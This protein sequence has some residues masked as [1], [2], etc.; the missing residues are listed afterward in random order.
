MIQGKYEK[1]LVLSLQ[2]YFRKRGYT[3]KPHAKLN[4]AWSN[5]ISDIDVLAFDNKE[6]VAVEVKSKRDV[7][8]RGFAQ[9]EKVAPFVD[10]VFVA[11]DDEVKAN[12]HSK[13]DNGSNG[14]G[15]LYVDL[16]YNN[17]VV[18]KNGKLQLHTPSI[19]QLCYLK[20]CCL[21]EMAREF[22][23]APHQSKQ[24]I[25][26]DLQR[27]VKPTILK[28]KL[29]EIVVYNKVSHQHTQK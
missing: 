25:A 15:I 13:Q 3:A 29:K 23:I 21:Q 20:K 27:K 9:V 16:I 24:Y 1:K 7:F 8:E 17:V 14:F 28:A 10:K 26:L 6:T 4:I 11:T 5:I 18:K 12:R 22:G 2:R 19:E